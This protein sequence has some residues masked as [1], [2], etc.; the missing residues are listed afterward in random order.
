MNTDELEID[1][2]TQK[3]IAWTLKYCSGDVDTGINQLWDQW[4]SRRKKSKRW[5]EKGELY[6]KSVWERTVRQ[7]QGEREMRSRNRCPHCG[8]KLTSSRCLACHL[9]LGVVKK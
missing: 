8:V 7:V 2:M 1:E 4:W 9:R 5:L 3:E 6:W